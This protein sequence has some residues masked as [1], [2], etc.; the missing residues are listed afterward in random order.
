MPNVAR[1]ADESDQCQTS[2]IAFNHTV[3]EI[4]SLQNS[5]CHSFATPADWL[6]WRRTEGGIRLHCNAQ[7][8]PPKGIE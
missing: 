5:Q 1:V 7:A 6:G 8:E 4:D 2:E 3:N